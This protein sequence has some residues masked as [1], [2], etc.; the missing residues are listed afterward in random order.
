[1]VEKLGP[2]SSSLLFSF[3][4]A[5][6]WMFRFLTETPA[7][8]P[9]QASDRDRAQ[10]ADRRGDRAAATG[11]LMMDP[12]AEFRSCSLY[13][14]SLQDADELRGRVPFTPTVM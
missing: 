8:V 9:G 12:C 4:V 11:K 5:V 13:V 2:G 7:E 3:P 10:S 1:M 14:E 6:V